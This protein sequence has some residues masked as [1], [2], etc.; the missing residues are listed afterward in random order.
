MDTTTS[1]TLESLKDQILSPNELH[2]VRD[3]LRSSPKAWR[4]FGDLYTRTRSESLDFVLKD[5]VEYESILYGVQQLRHGLLG[6]NYTSLEE[7]VVEQ[8]VNNHLR[9]AKADVKLSEIKHSKET[10]HEE[11]YWD[12]VHERSHN[13]ILR[14]IKTLASVRKAENDIK[15]KLYKNRPAHYDRNDYLD[16][17][18]EEL[19]SRQLPVEFYEQ[20]HH[21]LTREKFNVDWQADQVEESNNEELNQAINFARNRSQVNLQP[22]APA[23][24]EDEKPNV[25]EGVEPIPRL[26]E[27][28][29][30]S[31]TPINHRDSIWLKNCQDFAVEASECTAASAAQ[32]RPIMEIQ[33]D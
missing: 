11:L 24:N 10:E 31:P 27:G 3:L 16:K 25:Q 18:T 28:C 29:L 30:R 19:G 20:R 22:S 2:V 5:T 13:R 1:V 17:S 15:I 7:V 14:G 12:S 26:I 6:E 4:E 21:Q 9:A 33:S 8:I 32:H 23:I